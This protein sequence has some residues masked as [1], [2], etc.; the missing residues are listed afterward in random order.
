MKFIKMTVG[1]SLL[2][3]TLY[4]YNVMETKQNDRYIKIL[5]KIITIDNKEITNNTI[6]CLLVNLKDLPFYG[7]LS[8]GIDNVLMH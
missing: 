7:A 4:E 5:G 2:V 8:V 1:S 6:L 3:N